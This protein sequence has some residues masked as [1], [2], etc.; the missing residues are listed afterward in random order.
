MIYH[1]VVGDEAAKPLQEAIQTEP[2]MAGEVVILRDV[3]NVGPLQKTEGETFSEL[4]SAFWNEVI[5]NEK[6]P[7]AV[8]DMERMLQVSKAMYADESV[9]AW[10]WMATIP[11]D[12]CAY[13]WLLPYLSKH[14][15]RFCLINIA[16]L[17]F[18]DENGKVFYPKSFSQVLP[19]EIIKARRL[20]RPVTPAEVEVDTEEWRKLVEAD[21]G[22]RTAEGGKKLAAREETFYDNTLLGF[23]S[24]QYQKA[25]KIVTQALT[26]Y[27]VPTGDLYLGWRL[28]K[29]AEAGKLQLQGDTAKAL[30][31]FEIKLPGTP[32]DD[33]PTETIDNLTAAS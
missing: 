12:V 6:Q 23:C 17:P 28:R 8:D 14:T 26:K 3:L 21:S 29:M 25:S 27:S 24:P 32:T 2:L 31:D 33:T 4:R 16:G 1:F 5:N 13:Y 20:A 9:T 19:K 7:V 22:I 15:G 18:L 10:C 11:A 30:K